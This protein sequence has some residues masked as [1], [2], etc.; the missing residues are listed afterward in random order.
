MKK[1][2]RTVCLAFTVIFTLLS[3]ALAD[4]ST[5]GGPGLTPLATAPVTGK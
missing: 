2:P 3:T 5:G 1:T 4:P